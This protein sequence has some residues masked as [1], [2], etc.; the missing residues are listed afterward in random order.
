MGLDI[1]LYKY[2]NFEDTQTRENTYSE[3]SELLWTKKYDETP[4]YEKQEIR[5]KSKAIAEELMLDEW[6][7]DK[8]AKQKIE[9]NSSLYPEHYFKIGYFRSS[10]NDGGINRILDNLG[11]MGLYEIFIPND[12]YCFQ[13]DWNECLKRVEKALRQLNKKG[14]YRCFDVTENMFGQPNLPQSEKE[15]IQIVIDEL[16]HKESQFTAYSNNKGIFYLKEPLPVI[17]LIQGEN[18]MFGKKKCTYVVT[19]DE[20]NNSWYRQ[21]LEIVKETIEYVLAQPDKEKYYLHWSS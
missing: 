1:Y 20:E 5:E 14:N 3:K 6:G 7:E 2:E 21:A 11:V 4:E 9:I 12:E 13:P 19:K 16:T 18:N 8:T 15:A 17:A 10:Y